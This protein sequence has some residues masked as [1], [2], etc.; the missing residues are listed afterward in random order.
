[1]RNDFLRNVA[2][3]TSGNLIS[4]IAIFLL[5]PVITRIYSPQTFGSF[6]LFLTISSI[7]ISITSLRYGAAIIV[8]KNYK[9]LYNLTILCLFI[10]FILSIFYTLLILYLSIFSTFFDFTLL[11]L[12]IL[13]LTILFGGIYQTIYNFNLRIGHLYKLSSSKISKETFQR[14]FQIFFGLFGFNS[15][16]TLYLGVPIGWLSGISVFYNSVLKLFNNLKT[17]LSFNLIKKLIIK[18]ID[19]PKYI[20]SSVI[21]ISNREAPVFFISWIYGNYYLGLYALS[22]RIIG[23][24]INILSDSIT[25]SY[26]K[27]SSDMLRSK[28]NISDSILFLST[29]LL[30]L[31]SYPLVFFSCVISNYITIIFG[32]NWSEC[33][34]IIFIL[35]PFFISS[36]VFKPATS[37]FDVLKLQKERFY[38]CFFLLMLNLS[39]FFVAHYF[40][41]IN[42]ALLAFSIS[43]F[44]YKLISVFYLLIFTGNNLRLILKNFS[45]SIFLSIAFILPTLFLYNLVLPII[46]KTFFLFLIFTFYVIYISYKYKQYL[47][48][49]LPKTKPQ[50]S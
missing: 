2:I 25:K 44:L 8:S 43:N 49:F 18:Y 32:D 47:R 1:M 45:K 14:L 15:E 22:W 4:Q 41:N 30:L 40:S 7:G 33:S 31:I 3:L 38:N 34:T 21:E 35:I 29:N 11:D 42:Y 48:T 10:T 6:A 5:I 17:I 37:V 46:I 19:F 27:K 39:V 23:N 16:F 24:P 12:L 20:L 9:E 36:F 28:S 13:Y 50:K 26:Y